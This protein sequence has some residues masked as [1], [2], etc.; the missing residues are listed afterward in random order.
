MKPRWID[1]AF[2]A[3]L[4]A[5]ARAIAAPVPAAAP[6]AQAT[7]K[8]SGI[9]LEAGTGKVMTLQGAVANVFVADPK[10]AEVRPASATSLFVFGVGAGRT[11]IA[12]L[13]NSGQMI[14]QYEITVQ[15]SSFNAAQAQATIA[16]LVPGAR[17][18]VVPH[19]KGL[20][21]TGAVNDPMQAAQ[22]VAIAKTYVA[23]N[24][25]VENQL[26]VQSSV[27]VTLRVRIAEVQRNVLRQ[28]G[29]NWQ[30]LGNIGSIGSF[31]ALTLNFAKNLEPCVGGDPFCRGANFNGIID[32][33][34]QDN[35]ARVLAEPN[36]TAISG[37][38]ASVL[39]GGEFPVP[40]PGQNGQVTI[41]YKKFGVSL[42][43][44]PTVFSDGRISLHVAPEVS[45][46]SNQNNVT[47]AV[48]NSQ[49][50]VPSLTVRRAESTVELGSGESFVLAG[51]LQDALTNGTNG[52]PGLGDMPVL[53]ALFRSNS[54]Q[55]NETELVIV[56]TPFVVRPVMEA[57]NIHLP[58]EGNAPGSELDRLLYMRQTSSTRGP[59]VP[60]NIPGTGGF[61][62]Q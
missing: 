37:Q 12:A 31:P 20:L 2:A 32:A 36:L 41:D 8:P 3:M 40:V 22:A 62:V 50:V 24:Q 29:I 45:Q 48:A 19:T 17:V 43:F 25:M 56:V 57:S 16:R 7:T 33:L 39:V 60:V 58:T 21:L 23:D 13:D 18:K 5:A 11:T 14:A 44:V 26:S 51:L 46:L 35:L 27:Q 10:V 9:M 49:I 15:P 34:S 4:L 61:I 52:I 38:K 30:A 54:F 53:G 59:A 1:A 6:P 55:R 47:I 28:I 42:N